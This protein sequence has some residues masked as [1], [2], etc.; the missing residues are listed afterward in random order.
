MHVIGAMAMRQQRELV[1]QHAHKGL[2]AQI[3]IGRLRGIFNASIQFAGIFLSLDEC[4]AKERAVPIRV[5]GIFRW[6]P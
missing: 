6:S 2:V 4:L 3:T 5:D 1:A